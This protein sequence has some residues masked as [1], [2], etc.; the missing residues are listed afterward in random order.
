MVIKELQDGYSKAQ[1]GILS[2]LDSILHLRTL[3]LKQIPTVL[4]THM[5][6]PAKI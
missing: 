6:L 3:R 1:I 4:S 5:P 2:T